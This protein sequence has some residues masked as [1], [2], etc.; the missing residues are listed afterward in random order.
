MTVRFSIRWFLVAAVVVAWLATGI[1]SAKA[2]TPQPSVVL[3][4]SAI[5]YASGSSYVELALAVTPTTT[6]PVPQVDVWMSRCQF[7]QQTPFTLYKRTRHLVPGIERL[8]FYDNIVA[9]YGQ[10]YI[11]LLSDTKTLK[12]QFKLPVNKGG[13]SFCV[14]VWTVVGPAQPDQGVDVMWNL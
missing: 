9:H 13:G 10:W 3:K 4:A 7:G 5:P 2:E 14:H 1:A 8:R 11:P 6:Q 12:L